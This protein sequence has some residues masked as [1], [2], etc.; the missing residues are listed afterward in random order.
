[1]NKILCTLLLVLSFFSINAQ[2][3]VSQEEMQALVQRVDSLE[4][5]LAY[6]RWTYKLDK[7]SSDMTMLCSELKVKFMEI[8]IDVYHINFNTQ[9][10]N[11]NKQYYEGC[12]ERKEAIAELINAVKAS[13][14]LEFAMHPYTES[15][16]K[17][18]KS[19]LTVID[20]GYVLLNGA[21]KLLE[22]GIK[23]YDKCYNL[24]LKE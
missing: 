17:M 4:H 12:Q 14:I 19:N 15:E 10:A 16:K 22:S 21:M 3:Q 7:I 8:Q 6:L 13:L 2:T 1:M 24:Y 18:L 11:L 20:K 23:S 9:L 5:E